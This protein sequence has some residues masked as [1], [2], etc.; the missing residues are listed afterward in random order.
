MTSFINILVLLS[1]F[2]FGAR[3][4]VALSAPSL[5]R[6]FDI[7]VSNHGARVRYLIKAKGLTNEYENLSPVDLGGLKSDEYL[8]LNPQGKIPLLVTSDGLSIPESDVIARF[9]CDKHI[10]IAPSFVP[11][12]LRQRLLS[13]LIVR[14][15]DQVS[16]EERS[17][18]HKGRHTRSEATS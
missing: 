15:H 1:P 5:G 6:V 8:A 4:C 14:T 13:D 11:P 12:T 7:P 18:K 16:D 2:L 17:M 3:M 10:S 9:L